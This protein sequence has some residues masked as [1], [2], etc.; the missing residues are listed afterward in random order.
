[1]RSFW[2]GILMVTAP[3]LVGSGWPRMVV[4]S[5][6]LAV[7]GMS[8]RLDT[9][10]AVLLLG[11][12]V[13]VVFLVDDDDDDVEVLAFEFAAEGV[14]E[15]ILGARLGEGLPLHVVGRVGAAGAQGNFVIDDV[16]G[17]AVRVARLALEGIDG[18]R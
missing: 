14:L 2:L 10:M 15:A 12:T 13:L 1:M 16:A 8:V 11:M 17:A 6:G 7:H 5:V 9:W 4:Q 18:G 3:G